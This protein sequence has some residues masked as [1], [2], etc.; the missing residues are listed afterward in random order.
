MADVD[1]L[2]VK[3]R[4]FWHGILLFF[5]GLVTGLFV[6]S[7]RNPR[8][9]LSAHVGTVMSGMFLAVVGAA[10]PEVRLAEGA[11]SATFWLTLYGMYVSSAGLVLA[12]IL[13][14]SQTT[15]LA[16]AGFSGPAWQE[17]LVAFALISGGVAALFSCVGL[18]WGLRRRTME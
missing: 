1:P 18:L 6:Q 12:A 7:M 16:G 15:P 11:A 8:L 5:L 2:H 3:R 13:G 4:L 17:A 9:G 14:T 10:W